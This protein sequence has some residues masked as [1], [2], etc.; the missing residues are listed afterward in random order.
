MQATCCAPQ[1]PACAA[2][3]ARTAGPGASGP[4]PERAPSAIY[5]AYDSQT[6]LLHGL[7]AR[8]P[9]LAVRKSVEDR[10]LRQVSLLMALSA[11]PR[12]HPRVSLAEAGAATLP[13]RC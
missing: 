10:Y 4:T 8:Q 13:L 2:L 11:R 6:A 12:S 5:R 1:E 7:A 3:P 9:V